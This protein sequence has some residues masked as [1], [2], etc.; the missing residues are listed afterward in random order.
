M[1]LSLPVSSVLG[2]P[3]GKNPEVGCHSFLQGIFPTQGL[4]LPLLCLLHWLAG[5]SPLVPP[6]KAPGG[7]Y[8]CNQP[9][10]H[11]ASRQLADRTTVNPILQL[12]FGAKMQVRFFFFRTLVK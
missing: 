5:S 4:N 10:T 2:I 9:K 8:Y 12:T 6:G 11:G 7:P 1:D 3:P